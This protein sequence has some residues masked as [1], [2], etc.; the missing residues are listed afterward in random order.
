MFETFV[1]RLFSG[2]SR[3]RDRRRFA[4]TSITRRLYSSVSIRNFQTIPP[5]T[6]LPAAVSSVSGFFT[7][8][9][10]V[11]LK[12]APLYNVHFCRAR[13]YYFLANSFNFSAAVV[14]TRPPTVG[15]KQRCR[16]RCSGKRWRFFPLIFF[17]R[18]FT[19]S[20]PFERRWSAANRM[21]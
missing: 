17:P 2:A 8:V 20:P 7:S 15:D 12:T 14:S 5:T 10:R 13:N 18:C 1:L 6:D 21:R 19:L 11:R 4:E 9:G 16:Q 3:T